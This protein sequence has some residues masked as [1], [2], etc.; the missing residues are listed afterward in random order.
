MAKVRIVEERILTIGRR[1]TGEFVLLLNTCVNCCLFGQ[2][3]G[4]LLESEVVLYALVLGYKSRSRE[5]KGEIETGKRG[6]A[7]PLYL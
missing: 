4:S 6:L 3:D 5:L 2:V 1:K 7:A